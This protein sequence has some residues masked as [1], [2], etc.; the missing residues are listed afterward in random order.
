M[1]TPADARYEH[2]VQP[3][4]AAVL[5]NQPIQGVYALR[6]SEL[7]KTRAGKDYLNLELGDRTGSI[8][9]K[10]WDAT[11]SQ[12]AAFRS[13]ACVQITGRV[14]S[15]QGRA[16][17]RID[18]IAMPTDP[19]DLGLL[20]PT[21]PYDI[22]G[23]FERLSAHHATLTNPWLGSLVD[24]FLGDEAF[25]AGF[26]QAVAAS[27]HHH[28]YVGGLL[29]HVVSLTELSVRVCEVYGNL[30]RDLMLVGV[31]LHDVG[32]M[33]AYSV[34]TTIGYTDHGSLVG[35]IATGLLWLEERARAIE[36]FPADLL[37][38]LRHLVLSHHGK[39]EWGS[40]VPP[41]TPEAVALHAIDN[42]DAKMWA[43]QNACEQ[44]RAQGAAWSGYVPV[45]GNR[46]F[47]GPAAQ[48]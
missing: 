20:V 30:D 42:L 40:P 39:L 17:L 33:A 3:E 29:E 23:L 11:E 7:R 41:Q 1:I 46:V 18:Q 37:D 12:A 35:H 4:L 9:A 6:R 13:G 16:Q 28:A 26:K 34:G 15:Y 8:P 10:L 14:E 22:E 36:G 48:A 21:T 44:A 43:A 31:L 2:P 19:V 27:H 25:V 38:Q 45:L 32:K 5:P 24:G 47:A